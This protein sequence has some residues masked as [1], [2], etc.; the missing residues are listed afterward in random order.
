MQLKYLKEVTT[1]QYDVKKCIGCK[2]CTMVCPHGVF[3][4]E[5]KKAKVVN[6]DLCMECGACMRNCA[7]DAITVRPGVGCAAAIIWGKIKGTEPTCGGCDDSS[8]KDSAS[9]C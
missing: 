9:C 1:L 2:M 3:I 8:S 5:N 7:Y 6:K 4:I